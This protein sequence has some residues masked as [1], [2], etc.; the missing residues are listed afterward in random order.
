MAVEKPKTP[1]VPPPPPAPPLSKAEEVRQ[2]G[3]FQDELV[4]PGPY[5]SVQTQPQWLRLSTPE[6]PH[7]AHLLLWPDGKVTWK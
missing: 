1:G 5:E 4:E 3:E 7:V 6:Y 2:A